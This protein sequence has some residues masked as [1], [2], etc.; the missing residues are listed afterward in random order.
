[1]ERL[2]EEPYCLQLVPEH[3]FQTHQDQHL[4]ELLAA[5]EFEYQRQIQLGDAAVATAIAKDEATYSMASD[6]EDKDYQLA[7]TLNREFRQKEEQQH[8]RQVQVLELFSLT[9]SYIRNE[10]LVSKVKK[11]KNIELLMANLMSYRIQRHR[12]WYSG[13]I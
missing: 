12:K 11:R 6:T 13:R 2:C 1:M 8:F 3:L 9:L 10:R 7:L 5:E 4:A